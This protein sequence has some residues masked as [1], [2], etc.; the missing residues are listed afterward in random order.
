MLPII[1]VNAN[2][3][4]TNFESTYGFSIHESLTKVT[5]VKTSLV[6]RTCVLTICICKCIIY[7]YIYNKICSKVTTINQQ[8]TS[9]HKTN[10]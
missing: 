6:V 2:K 1:F 9:E 5:M 10:I 7:I 3:N 8:Q 4:R